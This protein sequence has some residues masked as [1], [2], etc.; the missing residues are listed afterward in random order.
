MRRA[1]TFTLADRNL[2]MRVLAHPKVPS[3][4]DVREK[5][6]RGFETS[7]GN[8][9]GHADGP[10]NQQPVRQRTNA[11]KSTIVTLSR[12]PWRRQPRSKTRRKTPEGKGRSLIMCWPRCEDGMGGVVCTSQYAHRK[13]LAKGLDTA[14]SQRGDSGRKASRRE[15]DQFLCT[16]AGVAFSC[17]PSHTKRGR[18][19]QGSHV[20]SATA[21]RTTA[22]PGEERNAI[23]AGFRQKKKKKNARGTYGGARQVAGLFPVC[24]KTCRSRNVQSLPPPPPAEA[25][26]MTTSP[27]SSSS[28]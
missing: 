20:I 25:F 7:Q 18:S 6:R 16:C 2:L 19:Q 4:L 26:S 8:P 21:E 24:I 17:P 10:I 15:E 12:H 1:M 11:V 14:D 5:A 27:S 22:E 28:S 13:P 3:N 9:R 23:M